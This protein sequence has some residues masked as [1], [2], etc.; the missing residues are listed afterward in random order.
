MDDVEALLAYFDS[1]A[2]MVVVIEIAGQITV[3]GGQVCQFAHIVAVLQQVDGTVHILQGFIHALHACV[4]SPDCEQQFAFSCFLLQLLRQVDSFGTDAYTFLV[5]VLTVEDGGK[6][7][8]YLQLAGRNLFYGVGGEGAPEV[9]LFQGVH[10]QAFVD[11]ATQNVDAERFHPVRCFG[12]IEQV[13]GTIGHREVD[14]ANISL[15]E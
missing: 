7:C 3:V 14:T 1:L 9:A 13:Q 5:L 2:V 4:Y 8:Q 11:H 12:F 15:G 10:T 6:L